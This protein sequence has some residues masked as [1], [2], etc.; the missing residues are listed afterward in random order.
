MMGSH[1]KKLASQSLRV[2]SDLLT[3]DVRAVATT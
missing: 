2:V 3:T 1:V